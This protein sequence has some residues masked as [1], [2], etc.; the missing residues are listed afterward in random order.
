MTSSEVPSAGDSHEVAVAKALLSAALLTADPVGIPFG[1]YRLLKELG[2]GGSGVV[3]RARRRGDYVDVALKRLLAGN[4]ATQEEREAF[5]R[6]ARAA[7]DVEHEHIVPVF[8]V[9]EVDG[10]PY[11]TMPL[12]EGQTLAGALEERPTAAQAAS[13]LAPIAR[14]VAHAHHAGVIHRDLKPA[15]ILI[16]QSGKP[17]VVDFG[18]ARRVTKLETTMPT[19]RAGFSYYMAP[20]QAEGRKGTDSVDIYAL[21]VILYELLTGRVPFEGSAFAGWIAELTSPDPVRPPS[22]MATR[23]DRD[24]ELVCLRCLEKDP[25]QR[26]RSA[27][28]LAEDLALVAAG[29]RPVHARPEPAS[30]QLLRW[31]KRRPLPLA[32]AAGLLLVAVVAG[33]AALSFARA[34]EQTEQQA[35]ETNAF[36]ANSHAGALLSQ[37]REFGDRV[38]RAAA[39]PAVREL[40]RS[41]QLDR[42]ASGLRELARGFESVYVGAPDGQLLAQWPSSHAA[43]I[44]GRN[45]AFRDYF[46][47]SQALARDKR[48]GVYLGRAFRAESTGAFEFAFSA[49]VYDANGE[50][51]GNYVAA[52]PADSVIGQVRMEGPATSGCVVALLGPRD[53]D[54]ETADQP[55]PSEMYFVVHPQLRHG[56]AQVLPGFASR[57]VSAAPGGQFAFR[58]REPQLVSDHH[59]T[60]SGPMEPWLAA[61][62]AVGDT[63]YAVV[64][65]TRREAV[66]GQNRLLFRALLVNVGMPLLVGLGLLAVAAGAPA[67]RK[68]RLALR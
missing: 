47:G 9:G 36:L 49:P 59:D 39:E 42:D 13:W 18:L 8:D 30:A 41:K 57:Y 31:A 4:L 38:E 2:R 51:L 32:I 50:W 43:R 12:I 1:D 27:D 56:Q 53:N 20:E 61:F 26:Y 28:L 10:C 7:A 22:A 16:D 45:Y 35:L 54:R 60:L 5:V 64:V 66:S 19:Q 3:F 23:V 17:W 24:L 68:R 65:Q 46:R 25:A 48:K 33:L 58:W 40:L 52:L 63:G 29:H 37:L 44:L 62:A 67:R 11:F 15:N 34:S 21:G 55:L 6:G 14:A